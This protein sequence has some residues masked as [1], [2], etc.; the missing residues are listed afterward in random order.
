MSE[1]EIIQGSE[2]WHAIRCGKATASRI[3]DVLAKGA[4]KVRASYLTELAVERLTGKPTVGY[5]SAAMQRGN[6]LEPQARAAYEFLR[7]EKVELVG[8]V[9]HPRIAMSGASPDGRV[10]ARGHV[11]IKCPEAAA[12]F[13]YL[14]GG[15]LP[16]AYRDQVQWEMACD[17]RDWCDFVSFNPD[18][19]AGMDLHVRRIARDDVE[20]ATMEAEVER[21]LAELAAKVEALHARYGTREAA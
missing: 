13:D 11:Q 21:F 9:H 8:F 1:A 10:G 2:D 18:F 4:G 6:D 15:T 3:S 17:G 12:H 5:K 19:P 7:R 14:E 16:K 20:I